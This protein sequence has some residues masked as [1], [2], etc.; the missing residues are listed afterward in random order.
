M[1]EG[2]A[3]LWEEKNDYYALMCKRVNIGPAAFNSEIQNN[4]IDPSTCT[5][6]EEWFDYW[7]DEGKTP[8]NFA[9]PRFLFVGAND[10]SLGKNK[11]ADTSS[12]FALAKDRITGVVYVVI[13]DVAQRHPDQIIE[14][15][16]EA[17]RRLKREF[18]RP[19][20]R[21]G[22]ETVQFQAYFAEVMRQKAAKSGEYLPIV[23]IN[24]TQNKDARIRSLQ[25]FVKN[26]YIKFS[27]K[28]KAL[29]QQ[30]KEYP[31]ARND[32]APDGLQMALQLALDIQGG[33]EVE[34]TTVL[35]READF[36]AGA[37]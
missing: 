13:A 33:G 24:S 15:V 22:V 29:L 25:P 37:Y 6:Q 4:P 5:F 1:L 19:Y 35:H 17:N 2:T 9:D 8:P 12:I 36:K 34:Y 21:F 30:M 31:M 11:R 18:H 7:E 16:L 14:D 23:E 27:K 32:D 26:G 28:H 20:Y 10:P 3:V